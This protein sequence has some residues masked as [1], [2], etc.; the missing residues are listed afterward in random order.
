M[1]LPKRSLK[2]FLCHSHSD[3]EAVRFLYTRLTR[4]GVDA[5]LDKE[6]LLPGQDWELEIRKAVR[7][8]DVV[9]VC[10]SKQFNQR[11]FRQ[12]EVRLALD[13]AME[14]PEGEIFIIP[15]RLEECE[16]LESLKKWH[17][18]DLFEQDGYDRLLRAL[19][20][21]GERIGAITY[22]LKKSD[23][24]AERDRK[25]K[26]LRSQ[27]AKLEEDSDWTA[28]LE[29]YRQIQSI[30]PNASVDEKITEVSRRG[31]AG[32]IPVNT[33]QKNRLEKPSSWLA[34]ASI[35]VLL[36]C[37]LASVVG[38]G[39]YA[40]SNLMPGVETPTQT[41]ETVN[42]DEAPVAIQTDKAE[43]TAAPTIEGDMV[44]IPA[45]EF[46]MGSQDGDPDE[47]PVHTVSLDAFYIDMYEVTNLQYQAC[48]DVGGC[49]S[50]TTEYSRTHPNYFSNPEFANYPVIHVSWDM[51]NAY[52][53][54]VG[55]RLP[56]EAEWEKAARGTDGLI[57]PWGNG[58][59]DTLVN[60]CDKNCP[61][62]WAFGQADDGYADTAPV[63]AFPEG[64]SPYGVFNLS[65]NVSEWVQDEYNS[66]PG[67]DPALSADYGTGL[68]VYRGGAW[69]DNY[70]DVRAV[71]RMFITPGMVADNLGIRCVKDVG[72]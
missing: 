11:G 17:W 35:G 27:A 62:G 20:S 23:F 37:C 53:Q 8:A 51:A 52:C 10:L 30:D 25:V 69:T 22:S 15:A 45:G 6:K 18:V 9:V 14:M 41:P 65:G 33:T 40:W 42:T 55:G 32:E 4:D 3:V 48:M 64:V 29:I 2:V 59:G 19:Y 46:S 71:N 43:V 58:F 70:L 60:F 28:A 57:Y 47:A 44:L 63:D 5:W 21:R 66:Y 56:T 24:I 72:Q 49:P 36:L 16:T 67:G 38:G 12:K 7:E 54:W 50:Q 61:F 26:F 1:T 39:W 13:T 31:Q 34:T 68:R